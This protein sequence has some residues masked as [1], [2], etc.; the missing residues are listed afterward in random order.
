MLK[1]GVEAVPTELEVLLR[2]GTTA[3][4]FFESCPNPINK[5]IVIGV[6]SA[7]QEE[8]R[9]VRAAK[10]SKNEDFIIGNL[11]TP[12]GKPLFSQSADRE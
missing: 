1:K 4:T 12:Y 2:Q 8:T 9:K 3:K 5:V 10:R 11:P 7:R 6:G